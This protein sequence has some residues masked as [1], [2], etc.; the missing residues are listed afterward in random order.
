MGL[1][2]FFIFILLVF[3]IIYYFLERILVW[4]SKKIL[5]KFKNYSLFFF[6]K[7][8]LKRFPKIYNFLKKRFNRKSFFGLSFTILLALFFY[9]FNEYIWLTKWV[10]NWNI[11][12]WIDIRLLDFF[13]YFRD[14]RLIKFFLFVSYLWDKIVVLFLVFFVSFY[15]IFKNKYFEFL[16][17]LLSVWLSSFIVFLSKNIIE[18][19]R[20]EF[21]SYIEKWYSF[22]SF[23]ATISISLYFYIIY[24]LII[25]TK[26]FRKKIYLFYFWIFIA[27]IIWFSRLYLRV[28]YF[29]DVIAWYFLGFLTFSFSIIFVNFLKNK[30]KINKKLFSFKNVKLYLYI[31]WFFWVFLLW[32]RYNLYLKTKKI[33]NY[34]DYYYK[35]ID[36]IKTFLSKKNI[37]F[38][39]TITWRKTENINFIFLSRSDYILIDLFKT[40]SWK[41]PD[42]I[43]R[44]SLIKAW[45]KLLE[46]KDYKT[47]PITP[48]YWNKKIQDFSFQKWTPKKSIKYRHHIRI[49]KTNYK[50]WDYFIYVWV[51]VYDDWIKWGITHKI[52]PNIDKEREFIFWSL[53]NNNLIESY[54]KIQLVKPFKW[55]NFSW[56]EF[57]TDWKAY[58]IKLK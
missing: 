51:W 39:E 43:W 44:Y 55:K 12:T 57:F 10:L 30:I 54:K 9:V 58:L 35:Q 14:E 3:V 17:F 56:D 19:P 32:F 18:R 31:F 28:H 41:M 53:V 23:H 6:F 40:S 8:K 46:W 49:W 42:R 7:N 27:F 38:S 2:S 52:D 4:Y 1:I 25:K 33:I 34:K 22:P 48:L 5:K 47:A 26:N 36:S 45:E 13:Y 21:A 37:K 15:L 16:G 50:I 24:L 29:S 20:P 11:I